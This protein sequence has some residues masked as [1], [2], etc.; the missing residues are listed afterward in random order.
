MNADNKFYLGVDVSKP[1]A[2]QAVVT[3][4]F[5]NNPEGIKVFHRFLKTDQVH[6]MAI[7]YW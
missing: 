2:K 5:E 7:V 6:L 4:R 1:C 3:E